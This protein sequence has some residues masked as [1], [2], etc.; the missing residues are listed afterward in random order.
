[1]P[2]VK[3]VFAFILGVAR[4]YV[5]KVIF[6]CLQSEAYEYTLLKL[7]T[8]RASCVLILPEYSSAH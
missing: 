5:G 8:R 3:A 6:A 4:R 2:Y 1:M 7:L